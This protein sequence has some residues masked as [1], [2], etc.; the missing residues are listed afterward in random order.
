M[1]WGTIILGR[2][3]LGAMAR[4]TPGLAEVAYIPFLSSLAAKVLVSIEKYRSY[5]NWST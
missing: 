4:R 5:S 3:T 2:K 1:L